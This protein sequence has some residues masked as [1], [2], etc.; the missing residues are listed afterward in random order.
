MKRP[1]RGP[2]ASRAVALSCG[3][4]ALLVV[5]VLSL[6]I[7]SRPVPPDVV[8]DAL[9][10][11]PVPEADRRAV[12]TLRLPR[13]VLALAVGIAL[14]VA[15]ALVQALTRNP[16]ADPGILGVTAG[17]SFAVALAV[18]VLGIGSSAGYLAFAF[19]GALAATVVVALV[20]GARRASIDPVRLTLAG[21]AVTAILAGVVSGLRVAEPRTFNALQAWE[22]GSF[23][24]RGW[25]T[26]APVWPFLAAGLLLAVLLAGPLNVVGLGE[27]TAAALGAS[28]WRTRLGTV[29]AVTLLAGGATAIAGPIS[30]IGLM[31]PHVARW[32]SG[33][34]QRWITALTVVL[35]PVLLISADI[36]AR[37]VV[38][39]GEMP[40][41]IVTAFLG[42]PVLI[43]LARRGRAIAL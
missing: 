32:I 4:A 39:P 10:G 21:V 15:G 28:P 20:G 6:G 38:W 24:G 2:A 22:A 18:A 7:G 26:A 33:P 3:I 11:H 35:A 1:G 42:A 12:V 37:V 31:V 23:V 41:G 8:L 40:V 25:A 5:I 9:L 13:T 14:G 27:E 17:A 16:L 29:L 36:L 19:A 43:A 30:F 34:D